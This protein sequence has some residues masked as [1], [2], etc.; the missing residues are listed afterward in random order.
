MGLVKNPINHLLK[1]DIFILSSLHEGFGNVL[2]E[3]MYSKL[4]IICSDSLLNGSELV[5]NRNC[6]TF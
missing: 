3:A 6:F 1:S 2:V 5:Y 4:K